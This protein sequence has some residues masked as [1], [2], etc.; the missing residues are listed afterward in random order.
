MKLALLAVFLALP[1]FAQDFV[2]AGASFAGTTVTPFG[3]YAHSLGSGIFSFE[4]VQVTQIHVKP[5]ITFQTVALQDFGY[6]FSTLLPANIQKH[7][8]LIGLGGLGASASSTALAGAFDG[9]GL[10]VIHTPHLEIVL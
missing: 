3:T 2:A 4:T 7:F 9:G 5:Q 10:G 8:G 6:D 1:V